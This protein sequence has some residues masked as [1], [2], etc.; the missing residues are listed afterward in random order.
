MILVMIL[1]EILL[2]VWYIK[3]DNEFKEDFLFLFM[4]IILI[5]FLF[6]LL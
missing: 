2:M 6:Y 1:L 3:L 5:L 4:L